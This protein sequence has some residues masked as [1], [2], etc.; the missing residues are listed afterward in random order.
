M[1]NE[2]AVEEA[3][4]TVRSVRA[5]KRTKRVAKN[6]A[7]IISLSKELLALVEDF[8]TSPFIRGLAKNISDSDSSS[9]SCSNDEKLEIDGLDYNKTLIKLRVAVDAIQEQLKT[10]TGS[11]VAPEVLLDDA[12]AFSNTELSD[13]VGLIYYSYVCPVLTM[14]LCL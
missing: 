14:A 7:E 10:L 12:D 6:C 4:E 5:S 1:Q 2:E 9:I 8:P 3:D 11:T 13:K